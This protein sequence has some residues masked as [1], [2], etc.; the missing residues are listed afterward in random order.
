MRAP[1]GLELVRSFVNTVDFEDERDEVAAW[2]A[3]RGAEPSRVELERARGV[4]EALRGLLLANNGQSANTK[5]A[6]A[7]LEAAAARA[8]LA[9][10]FDEAGSVRLASGVGGVD[11]ILGGI[12]AEVAA[13]QA[14]GTWSRLKACRMESCRWAFYDSAKN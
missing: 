11:G 13:A 2:L 5:A 6:V 4:R 10:R 14:E 1:G 7:T 8:R 9:L 3:A 12:L